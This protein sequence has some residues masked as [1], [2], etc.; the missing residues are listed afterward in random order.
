MMCISATQKTQMTIVGR[1]P[2][3]GVLWLCGECRSPAGRPARVA[4]GT[5]VVGGSGDVWSVATDHAISVGYL[6][7]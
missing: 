3:H 2:P 7:L 1:R 6:T 4:Q 5:T